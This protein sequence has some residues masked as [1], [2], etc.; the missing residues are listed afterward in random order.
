MENV[1][2][3]IFVNVIGA[4]M[5]HSV[6]TLYV[7]HHVFMGF[8]SM[9]IPVNAIKAIMVYPVGNQ[10]VS[11]VVLMPLVSV[12]ITALV[13]LDIPYLL[14]TGSVIHQFVNQS[15]Y[16]ENVHLLISVNV[17]MGLW[18]NSVISVP[19]A[20]V[21]LILRL[22]SLLDASSKTQGKVK[23]PYTK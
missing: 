19:F 18:G 3:L 21:Y 8:A 4:T 12:L 5:A 11:L 10:S 22:G 7:I 9:P 14:K 15:V 20:R 17:I 6:K 16:M 1:S 23:C 13:M 2:F